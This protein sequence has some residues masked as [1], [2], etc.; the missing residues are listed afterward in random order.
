MARRDQTKRGPTCTGGST[1]G[2]DSI[3]TLSRICLAPD[4]DDE[5]FDGPQDY[6]T[7]RRLSSYML[8]SI[9][10]F[11][12]TFPKFSMTAIS[13]EADNSFTN[14]FSPCSMLCDPLYGIRRTLRLRL[15]TLHFISFLSTALLVCSTSSVVKQPVV[16]KVHH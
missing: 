7:T 16:S 8:E 3:R 4:S 11:F 10:P 12:H 6:A 1:Q 13:K 9:Y 14:W 2:S 15:L 5:T